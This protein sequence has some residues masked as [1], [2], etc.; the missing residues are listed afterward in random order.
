MQEELARTRRDLDGARSK[1]EHQRREV[2][3]LRDD[4][5][6]KNRAYDNQ[7]AA[8][9]RMSDSNR[10]LREDLRKRE[11]EIRSLRLELAIERSSAAER[12]RQL[13]RAG[14]SHRD[15][16]AEMRRTFDQENTRRDGLILKLGRDKA[17]AESKHADL[18]VNWHTIPSVQEALKI[19]FVLT[20]QLQMRGVLP[21]WHFETPGNA[22]AE[23]VRVVFCRLNKYP[24]RIPLLLP[25]SPSNSTGARTCTICA[26]DYHDPVIRSAEHW[27]R[28]CRGFEGPWTTEIFSFPAKDDLAC[29]HVANVCKNCLRDQIASQLESKGSKGWN[30]LSCPVCSRS[31]THEEVQR[32]AAPE[33]FA[34]YER[35]YLIEHLSKEPGFR[36][37][38]NG[39]CK[40]GQLYENTRFMPPRITCSAAGC[41]F[42]MCFRHQVP[43]HEG[44]TCAEYDRRLAHAEDEEKSEQWKKDN[45]KACPGNNCGRPIQKGEGCFHMTCRECDHEFCWECL[46]DWSEVRNN[47]LNHRPGCFFRTSEVGPMGMRGSTINMAAGNHW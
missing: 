3:D 23:D 31:L 2:N 24:F 33:D 29:E 43:W 14:D 18:Q 10:N 13:L 11:A 34:R 45:T 28:S 26:N 6:R 41:N 22:M 39:D 42:A 35:F 15:E 8:L 46:A 30:K 40:S 36:W 5:A 19:S 44:L 9:D 4:L 17:E 47:K 38:L 37:C 32:F 20:D 27:T 7:H 25:G 16:I 1:I 21:A 12:R